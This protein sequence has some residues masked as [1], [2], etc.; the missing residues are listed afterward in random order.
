MLDLIFKRGG[1]NLMRAALDNSTVT[2]GRAPE[3]SIRLLDPEISRRHCRIETKEG[4]KILL[5]LS[6]NGILLNGREI[7]EKEITA[8]DILTIGPWSIFVE[9]ETSAR[10]MKTIV[11]SPV[12]TRIIK[13]DAEDGNLT[14]ESIEIS[15]RPAGGGKQ[16]R[17][18][19][20]AEVT[21]GQH[22][23][24]EFSLKDSF[25]SKHHCKIINHD[26]V[27]KLMDLASTNGTFVDSVRVGKMTL[28]RRG[29]F[30]IG[31]TEIDCRILKTLEKIGRDRNDRLGD[32]VGRSKSIRG[33]FRLIERVAP[34]DSS[35]LITGESGTGK[36]VV[37]R[38]IHNLSP[39]RKGPFVAINC[40]AM[41][42]SII[43]SQ[44]FGHERGAF[45][46]AVERM[47]G[48]FEQAKSGTLFLDEIAEMPLDLQTRLLRVLETKTVRRVGGREEIEVNARIIAATNRNL[49]R[50]VSEKKFREDLFF[51]LYIV[52]IEIPPLRGRLDDIKILA[53]FFIGELSRG[54]GKTRLTEKALAKLSCHRWPG[55]VRELK[56][57]I[58]RALLFARK[59]RIDA[60][61]LKF[62]PLFG[63]PTAVNSLKESERSLIST[64][65]SES[66]GNLS[67]AARKLGVARTSLQ[68]KIKR[69]AIP[70][71]RRQEND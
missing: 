33:V 49:R 52:P 43:E 15:V 22:P 57:T 24:C 41:P 38:E 26:G 2:I 62:I 9:E 6:R 29:S 61:D 19:T 13:Y 28:G 8:G 34:S 31:R 51:R 68:K 37:A 65:I 10:P 30:K 60:G 66:M 71:P 35:I 12:A 56:N 11:S 40:G 17:S 16:K 14:T 47:A 67:K 45:T 18:F 63:A 36:E 53:D 59:N 32:M 55:N 54:V 7:R 48:L 27:L 23:A 5:D 69:L 64:T 20:T 70:T 39:R 50:L 3:N 25:V 42:A 46:G 21:I 1:K 44:L 4:K 58:E